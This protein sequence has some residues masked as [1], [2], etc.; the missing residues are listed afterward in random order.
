M[1]PDTTA[2]ITACFVA[3]TRA[4]C[5]KPTVVM[6]NYAAAVVRRRRTAMGYNVVYMIGG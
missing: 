3:Q 1:H 6:F 2:A 5:G 4:Q